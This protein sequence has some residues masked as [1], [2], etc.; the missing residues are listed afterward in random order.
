MTVHYITLH[1]ITLLHFTYI[2]LDYT[3]LYYIDYITLHCIALHCIALRYITY[4]HTHTY[5]GIIYPTNSNNIIQCYYVIYDSIHPLDITFMA[6]RN[7]GWLLIQ[8]I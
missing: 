8:Y 2:T 1:H 7:G 3:T 6:D 5:L 4:I